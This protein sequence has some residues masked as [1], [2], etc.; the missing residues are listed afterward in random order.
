MQAPLTLQIW[1]ALQSV[2][3]LH[4]VGVS[5]A[6][7]MQTCPAEQSAGPVHV[8]PPSRPPPPPPSSP[9][10][11]VE[12]RSDS[13]RDLS[14][15]RPDHKGTHDSTARKIERKTGVDAHSLWSG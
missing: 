6:P 3:A 10:A 15:I 13:Q 1:S 5:H 12:R 11:V 2:A 14:R 7:P 4:V 8:A 9:H